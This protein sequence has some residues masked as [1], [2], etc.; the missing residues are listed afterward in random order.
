VRIISPPTFP[1]VVIMAICCLAMAYLDDRAVARLRTSPAW[2]QIDRS[3]L[4]KLLDPF[5]TF[6]TNRTPRWL[7]PNAITLLGFA[8]VAIAFAIVLVYCP[9]CQVAK[10]ARGRDGTMMMF[11]RMAAVFLPAGFPF[12]EVDAPADYERGIALYARLT[13]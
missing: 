9:A 10:R 13:G 7:A 8:P 2:K 6:A 12:L 3:V 1:A 5:W 11:G 4:S